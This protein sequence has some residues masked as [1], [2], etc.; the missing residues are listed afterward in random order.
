[1]TAPTV[2][3]HPGLR[4]SW[5][6]FRSG[7]RRQ[8]NVV[9]ALMFKDF[10]SRATAGK[11]GLVWVIADPV[12][13]IVLLSTFWWLGGRMEISGVHVVLFISV[14]VVPFTMVSHAMSGTAA[15]MTANQAFYNYPQVKPIDALLARFTLDTVLLIVG[16]ILT[17]FCLAWF[18]D[19]HLHLHRI[20]P[21]IGV[22][23]ITI[24]LSFGIALFNATYG[25]L[26]EGYSKTMSFLSRPLIFISAVFYTPNDL[27][28]QA[29]YILSWNPIAQL[30]EYA[31][32]YALGIRLFPEASLTYPAMAAL[33]VLFMGFIAYYPNRF[34]LIER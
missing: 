34:R 18:F 10:R 11:L 25:C 29:R 26:Y 1:M 24:A 22:M 21:L 23:L 7:L 30:V 31:R 28:A 19:L 5:F 14:A 3:Q 20:L 15:A 16:A 12:S 8:G 27:P 2:S 9:L 4:H 17:F 33:I 6:E 32:L 13:K